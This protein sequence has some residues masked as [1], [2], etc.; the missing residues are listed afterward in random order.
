[1]DKCKTEMSSA[2][3]FAKNAE[4]YC[5]FIE[6]PLQLPRDEF[7]DNIRKLLPLLYYQ[8]LMLPDVD[9]ADGCQGGGVSHEQWKE[10]YV[11]LKEYFGKY[12]LFWVVFDP[13]EQ[14]DPVAA[15]L[16]DA[17]ADIWRDLKCGFLYWE[18]GSNTMKEQAIFEWRMHFHLHW[19]GHV[20]DSLRAINS[21]VEYH[22]IEG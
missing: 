20:V 9:G 15:S 18:R 5:S 22:D 3:D 7:L 11:P 12:D 1:M 19:S 10:I 6:G 16:S 17:L 13:M 2:D 4:E 21:I 14:E 8:A